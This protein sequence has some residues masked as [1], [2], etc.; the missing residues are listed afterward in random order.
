MTHFYPNP[1]AFQHKHTVNPYMYM[2]RLQSGAF[3]YLVPTNPYKHKLTHTYR[4]V[5]FQTHLHTHMQRGD[6]EGADK[7]AVVTV[8]TFTFTLFVMRFPPALT[9]LK[10]AINQTAASK[11][12]EREFVGTER[13]PTHEAGYWSRSPV[14]RGLTWRW[15]C[16]K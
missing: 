6:S 9:G 3:A 2:Q 7:T 14:W 10:N 15:S 16:L 5:R 11:A 13:D 12:P 8:T 1:P 4:R